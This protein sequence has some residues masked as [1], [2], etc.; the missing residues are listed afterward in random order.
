MKFVDAL[1][2]KFSLMNLGTLNY[3]FGIELVPQTNGVILSQ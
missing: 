1:L 2:M 3:F